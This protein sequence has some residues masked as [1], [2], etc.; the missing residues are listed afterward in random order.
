MNVWKAGVMVQDWGCC[1]A[2]KRAN[3][4]PGTE[5]GWGVVVKIEKNKVSGTTSKKNWSV[6]LKKAK[7]MKNENERKN[8]KEKSYKTKEEKKFFNI[9]TKARNSI[10]CPVLDVWIGLPL[11]ET[12]WMHDAPPYIKAQ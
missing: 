6:H 5:W 4:K 8:F 2:E 3:F 10:D 1:E 9:E 11:S 12:K 7:N